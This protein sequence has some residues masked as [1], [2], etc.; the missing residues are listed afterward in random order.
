MNVSDRYLRFVTAVFVTLLCLYLIGQLRA[1]F[2]D[3]W[4][5]IKVVLI[6]FLAALIISYILQP[7]VE[8]LARRRVPRAAAIALIYISFILLL[9]VIVVNCIPLVSQQLN[10]L[11]VHLPTLAQRVDSWLDNVSAHTRYLPDALRKSVEAATGRLEERVSSWASRLIS[12][13]SGTLNAVFVAFTVPFLVFYMLKDAR[14]IGRAMVRLCPARHRDEVRHILAGIDTTLGRYVR[15][16][17]LV[18]LVVG[19]LTYAGL[20]IVHM[21]YALLLA[22]LMALMDLV[23][24]IGPFLGATPAVLLAFAISPQMALKVMIVNAVVQQLEGN[25]ISP[26]IMGRTLDLHP[27]LIVAAILI[28]GEVGG[29]LGLI[30]AVPLVA[31][32]KVAWQQIRAYRHRAE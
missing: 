21:P 4:D 30:A 31:V 16:Q 28:G 26:Q 14:A 13:L 22:L 24:Y 10:Q 1:F 19:V 18:M 20:L 12:G 3:I 6:P 17:L 32:I 29:M 5:V 27:M 15:G 9:A 25:L 23:P 2:G 7:I 11:I 8:L